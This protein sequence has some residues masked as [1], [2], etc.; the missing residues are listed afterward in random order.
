[1]SRIAKANLVRHLQLDLLQLGPFPGQRQLGVAHA[2]KLLAEPD[3]HA[4][5]EAELPILDSRR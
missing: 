1:M 2:R 3:R 5:L 4:D